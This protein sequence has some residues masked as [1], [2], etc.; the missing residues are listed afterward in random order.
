MPAMVLAQLRRRA[1]RTVALLVGILVAATGFT[2]LTGTATTSRQVVVGEV[3][4]NFRPSYDLLVRPTGTRTDLE[5][6]RG[7]VRPNALAGIPGGITFEQY[8]TVRGMP[9]VEVAAPIAM[10]GAT[11]SASAYVPVDMSAYV[12]GPGSGV[13]RAQITWSTD[14]GLTRIPDEPSYL[15]VSDRP[16]VG[17]KFEG[18]APVA[19][20]DQSQ[21]A[22]PVGEVG[23]AGPGGDICGDDGTSQADGPYAPEVRSNL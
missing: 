10:V 2:V 14:R 5:R 19:A 1:G 6:D 11:L 15:Y 17:P 3:E 9:G 13:L 16:F 22:L 21:E 8:E 18:A 20:L 12:N 7:L 23:P 4:R